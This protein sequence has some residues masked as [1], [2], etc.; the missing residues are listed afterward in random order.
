MRRG[1]D[2]LLPLMLLIK[3]GRKRIIIKELQ[4]PNRKEKKTTVSAL[5]G[6]KKKPNGEGGN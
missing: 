6:E 1:T 2:G 4:H 3:K 5:R